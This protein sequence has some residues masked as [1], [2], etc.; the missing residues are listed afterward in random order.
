MLMYSVVLEVTFV[1]GDLEHY[2]PAR[3][4]TMKI[5]PGQTNYIQ[6]A[7]YGK[8]DGRW[9]WTVLLEDKVTRRTSLDGHREGNSLTGEGTFSTRD[10]AKENLKSLLEVKNGSM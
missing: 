2:T 5:I 7:G 1:T 9:F 3:G 6:V 4:Q 8:F 10:E